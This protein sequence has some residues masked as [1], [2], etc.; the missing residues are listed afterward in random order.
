M[1]ASNPVPNKEPTPGSFTAWMACIRPKTLGIAIAPVA[2]G[3]S[4]SAAV[5]HTFNISVAIA[6]LLLSILM[7]S[8]SN[9]ENDAGYTKKKAERS[10]RKGLPRATANGWL[11]VAQVE[12]MIAFFA[13][14]VLIDTAYLIWQ[15][16]WVMLAISLA[17][18]TAAYAYMGGPKPIAY[19][20]FGELVVFIFFGPV[21]VCG[22]YWLQTLTLDIEPF[23]AGSALG[24]IAA[25]VL[26]VNNFRDLHHDQEVG[27]KTLAVLLGSKRMTQVYCLMLISGFVLVALMVAF[28]PELLFAGFVAICVPKAYRLIRELKVKT[29][30]ELNSVMFGTIQLELLFALTLTLGCLLSLLLFLIR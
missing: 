27:R 24:V 14:L 18:I 8:I 4:V 19:T 20:P 22:T 25:G 12:R 13:G 30:N 7:Q 17:S 6:T 3:L 29:G 2:V 15:G 16:G 5:T 10:T 23:L 28:N 9:M 1:T 11:T 26:A 21:A